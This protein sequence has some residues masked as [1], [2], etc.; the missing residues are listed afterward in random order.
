MFLK[1]K[2]CVK[3]YI[4]YIDD[5]II[6]CSNKKRLSYVLDEVKKFLN[7]ERLVLKKNYQVFNINY[8]DL[9]FLGFRF[10][11]NKTI[12]R[13]RNMIRISRRARII[14][15]KN[16]INFKDACVMV[17]YFG[18]IKRSNSYCFY[19]NKIKPYIK[20]KD[21]KNIISEYCKEQG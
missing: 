10:Y 17:S 19:N 6:L 3:Y 9:D 7:T 16:V 5:L 13:K 12:L 1:E 2:L 14:C 8:R 4:R 15:K 11:H 21:M 18:W 20:M